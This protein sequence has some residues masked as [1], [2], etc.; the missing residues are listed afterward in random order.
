MMPKYVGDMVETKTKVGTGDEIGGNVVEVSTVE[1]LMVKMLIVE[2]LMIE[3]TKNSLVRIP[4]YMLTCVSLSDKFTGM[5]GVQ[6]LSI[7]DSVCETQMV[8]PRSS[9]GWIWVKDHSN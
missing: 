1:I 6:T 5:S 8:W 2:V 3:V 7:L 9:E 4:S